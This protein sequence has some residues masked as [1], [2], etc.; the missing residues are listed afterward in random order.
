VVRILP[1]Y[2]S[3][4]IPVSLVSPSKRL[5]PASVVLLRDFLAAKLAAL[6]WRG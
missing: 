1:G 6:R 5:E 2:V 3:A 4:D